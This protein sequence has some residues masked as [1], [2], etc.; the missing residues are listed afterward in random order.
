[1]FQK[2]LYVHTYLKAKNSLHT[3]GISSLE[4]IFIV[5]FKTNQML[6]YTLFRKLGVAIDFAPSKL[7]Q[8]FGEQV[9]ELIYSK[10]KYYW[11][12]KIRNNYGAIKLFFY[13]ILLYSNIGLFSIAPC[14]TVIVLD[15]LC[16][17][18]G[19]SSFNYYTFYI[20][21]YLS[22]NYRTSVVCRSLSILET[23]ANIFP[24]LFAIAFK[25]RERALEKS[26]I[27]PTQ[28]C[29]SMNLFS[30][31]LGGPIIFS[32]ILYTFAIYFILAWFS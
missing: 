24:L 26:L 11:C 7:K 30:H 32:S 19:V 13:L 27:L 25:V 15:F 31:F 1:M 18:F 29:K 20:Y 28:Y 10:R 2:R 12:L 17:I 16:L 8:G 4:H 23:I 21:S 22:F 5:F 14:S 3:K 6:K 9:F